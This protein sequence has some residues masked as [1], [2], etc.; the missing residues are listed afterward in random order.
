MPD[1]PYDPI[2]EPMYPLLFTVRFFN[3]DWIELEGFTKYNQNLTMLTNLMR[4]WRECRQW[5][6]THPNELQ[7]GYALAAASCVEVTYGS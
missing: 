2:V 6:F 3:E 4:H 7:K 1:V 5:A